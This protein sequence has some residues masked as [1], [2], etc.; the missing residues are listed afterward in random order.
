MNQELLLELAAGT[1]LTEDKILNLSQEV[2]RSL[3]VDMIKDGVPGASKDQYRLMKLLEDMD[4]SAL[5][6]KKIGSDDDNADA[7][8]KAQLMIARM[9]QQLGG[10]NPLKQT[11]ANNGGLPQV[12]VSEIPSITAKPGEDSVGISELNYKEFTKED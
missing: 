9:Q 4:G 6:N 12:D 11:G 2:R 8:R 1:E 7:D 5:A 3:L 10:T